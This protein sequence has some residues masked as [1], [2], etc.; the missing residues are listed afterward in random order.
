MVNGVLWWAKNVEIFF[1]NILSCSGDFLFT[2][3]RIAYNNFLIIIFFAKV[4]FMTSVQVAG[5]PSKTSSSVASDVLKLV[6]FFI[7]I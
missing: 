3:N 2:I 1:I 5:S 7:K 4:S 6:N